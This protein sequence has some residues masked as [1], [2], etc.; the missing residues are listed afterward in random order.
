MTYFL[1]PYSGKV[2]KS[3]EQPYGMAGERDLTEME[4]KFIPELITSERILT[5]EEWPEEYKKPD[6]ELK[7]DI[8]FSKIEEDI[9][10][11]F[12]GLNDKQT[13]IS[14]D[15]LYNKGDWSNG[16]AT[17][18]DSVEEGSTPS[19][20]SKIECPSHPGISISNCQSCRWVGFQ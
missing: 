9:V 18:S 7:I 6:E 13:S 17:D 1:D 20:P 2:K 16:K 10:N 14:L 5:P 12:I 4:I 8:D 15:L 19:S 11:A 3:F